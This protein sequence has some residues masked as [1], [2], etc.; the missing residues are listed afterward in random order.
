[1]C[2]THPHPL[3]SNLPQFVC[4]PCRQPRVSKLRLHCLSLHG[5]WPLCRCLVRACHT[6]RRAIYHLC[7]CGLISLT[8]AVQWV[9]SSSTAGKFTESEFRQLAARMTLKKFHEH[10]AIITEG[11]EG[12]E[13]FIIQ[14]VCAWC[15]CASV[16]FFFFCHW[17]WSLSHAVMPATSQ[18]HTG[19]AY[20]MLLVFFG[21][22]SFFAVRPRRVKHMSSKTNAPSCWAHSNPVIILVKWRCC[23]TVRAKPPLL[24]KVRRACVCA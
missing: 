9:G 17:I 12:F 15:P 18:H 21:G 19:E 2:D 5:I 22:S 8:C 3:T 14:Q 23:A 13:F 4:V 7:I 1:M 24:S 11:E 20:I 16:F 10:E 6:L